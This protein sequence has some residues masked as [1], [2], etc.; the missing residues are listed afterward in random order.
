MDLASFADAPA[1]TRPDATLDVACQLLFASGEPLTVHGLAAELGQP[2]DV[3]AE[4]VDG[5]ERVGRIRRGEDGRIVAA[6]GI[7]V[8]PSDYELRLGGLLRWTWC[9]K[10]GLGVLGA[11]AAG[12]TLSTR[13]AATG[14]TVTVTFDGGAPLPTAAAVLWPSERF[15]SSCQS[16]ADELCATFSLFAG[17]EA[18]RGWA[19]ARGLDA[20]VL[21][22]GEA[23]GR[24]V[25]RYRYSLG[26]PAM[27]ERL[28][29]VTH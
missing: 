4:A 13:C 28:L 29:G 5:F 21:G 18:A 25:D 23:T 11:L 19:V 10:T 3:V 20:E 15:Q 27:R 16:A 9:A 8:V 22:V 2:P 6:A 26:L 12:G 1:L 14:D 17:A 24:T 7:S